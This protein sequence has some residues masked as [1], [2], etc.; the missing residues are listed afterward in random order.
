M[1]TRFDFPLLQAARA[2][3]SLEVPC[4]LPLEALDKAEVDADGNVR[5]TDGRWVHSLQ[6]EPVEVPG[7]WT[8]LDEAIIWLTVKAFGAGHLFVR[9]HLPFADAQGEPGRYRC[10]F[11][12]YSILHTLHEPNVKALTRYINNN[13]TTLARQ[14]GARPF[15]RVTISRVR[16]TLRIAGV[17]KVRGHG[18]T[19]AA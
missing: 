6:F 14:P 18:Q 9:R 10:V 5:L 11:I 12:D 3:T 13:L 8:D 2:R 19:R 4:T 7:P 17:T 15:K 1:D 16:S